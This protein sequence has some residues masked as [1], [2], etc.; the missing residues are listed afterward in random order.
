MTTI[1]T[2]TDDAGAVAGT[3]SAV[4]AFFV[5]VADWVTSTD[6]K[7]IGR[8]YAGFGL[9]VLTAAAV[10]GLVL[11]L[12]RADDAALLDADALLQTFQLYRVGIVFGGIAP[13]ALGLAVAVTP[14]QLGARSIA[15]PR[16][17]LTGFYAWLGGFTL[18]IVAL[19]RNGGAGGGDANM[20]DL[21]LAGLGLAVIGLCATA[22]TVATSVLTTRAPG[23]TMRR[24]P[25]FAWSSLI[26]ALGMLI[27][28]PVTFGVVIY[29]FI[30][31]R[32]GVQANFLGVE[33]IG[34]WLHWALSVPAVVVYALPAVGVAAEQ[35]PVAFKARQAL[36]GVMFA[37]IALVG[38][39]ALAA[40]TQQFT[41][42]VTFDTD[43][44]TFLRGAVP[45]AVFIGLPLL[46]I[47]G[48]LLLALGTMRAGNG[49]PSIRAPFVFGILGLLFVG[50]GIAATAIMNITDL[51]LISPDGT[52]F[53]VFEEGAT[54]LVV[55]GAALA[56]IGGLVFWA[57]KLW[58]RVVPDG[59]AIPLALLGAAGTALAA[60]PL[61]VAGF[62]DQLGG[63]P[64]SDADVARLLDTSGVD[65]AA[66]LNT[67]SLVGHGLMALTIVA[68]AGLMLKTFTGSADDADS[69]D[70]DNPY[71]GHT[72]EWGT[73]SP[74]PAANYDHV[75]TVAS[76]E[77]QFDLTH[78]QTTDQTIEG[79][80]S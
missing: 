72:V 79:S 64:S 43:G 11:G 51:E 20:V 14:L 70:D 8:L 42:E 78:D 76:A 22:G 66:A 69:A 37:A 26:G 3:P 33:G 45:F 27:S 67:L 34:S 18:A 36:R 48:T 17:A 19:G 38:I 29:L 10:L 12:E 55:Y 5:G 60:V 4:E 46:G 71:G 40:A 61:L 9:L 58:G 24:V 73:T 6:H 25:L 68:V 52:Q 21:Y 44:E 50:A 7:K 56:A 31:H 49:R 62:L 15:F 23:M 74:A 41:Q 59:A 2:H 16:L 13:L 35:V 54:L 32:L 30:D 1:D 75:V 39:T 53:T 63:V 65:G 28:L 80:Q 77:P 47:T 57:P